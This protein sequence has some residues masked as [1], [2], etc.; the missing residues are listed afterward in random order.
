LSLRVVESQH[1]ALKA[2]EKRKPFLNVEKWLA[3]LLYVDL[4]HI[5]W[6]HSVRCKGGLSVL[7]GVPSSNSDHPKPLFQRE[8]S[9]IAG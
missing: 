3:F 5:V 7:S 9:G 6:R 4:Q 8:T 2:M 1:P